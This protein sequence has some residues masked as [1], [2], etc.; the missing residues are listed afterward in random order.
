MAANNISVIIPTLNAGTMID[1]LL[2][3]LKRQTITPAEIIVVDSSSD[4]DTQAI[5]R[6]KHPEVRLLVID[7]KDFNHGGTRD[8]ALRE[9]SGEFVCFLTQDALPKNN[10]FW[11]GLSGRSVMSVWRLCMGVSCR[12]RTPGRLSALCA[13]TLPSPVA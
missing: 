2:S 10:E 8:Y 9:S 13:S 3:A 4:D 11:D 1:D 5:V 12:A 6:T 7:R